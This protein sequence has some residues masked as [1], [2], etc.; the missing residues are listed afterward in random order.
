[1]KVSGGVFEKYLTKSSKKAPSAPKN[2]SKPNLF[3]NFVQF[4]PL[5]EIFCNCTLPL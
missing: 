3:G 2:V 1:M 4:N 5:K